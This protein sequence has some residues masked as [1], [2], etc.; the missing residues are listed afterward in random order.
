MYRVVES[1]RVSMRCAVLENGMWW[2]KRTPKPNVAHRRLGRLGGKVDVMYTVGGGDHPSLCL[3][4][5]A[6]ES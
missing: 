2:I 6:C 3:L 4:E 5:E 1:E